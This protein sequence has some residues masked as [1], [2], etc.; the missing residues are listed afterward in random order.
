[1][2]LDKNGKLLPKGISWLPKKELY[3]GRFQYEGLSYAVYAKTLREVKKKLEDQRYQVEHG[4]TGRA[5]R[6]TLN[7]WFDIWLKTYKVGK[8]KDTTIATYKSL[9]DRFVR[10]TLG[11]RYITK[12]KTVEVQRLYN[13]ITEKGLSPKYLKTLH[14]T[15]SNIFKMAVNNDII[16]KNPC[17]QTIRPG[18]DTPERRVLTASEQRW[19]LSFIQQEQYRNIEP[20]ITVLLGTGL[21]IGELLGLKW[22][23]LDLEGKEKTLTVNRTLVR[24]RDKKCFAFQEPKTASGTRTIP[25]QDSVVR[26]LKRQKVNQAHQKLS[27]RWNPPTGFEG[28]VFAGKKGQPQWRSCIAESLDKIIAAMNADEEERA[29]KEHRTPVVI[30]HINLHACRHSFA[31]RCLEAG[32][33]PKIVQSWLGHSSIEITLDLY[34]HVNQDV[35]FENMRRLEALYSGSM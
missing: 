12:I 5:D 8:V 18:I 9:Y 26:A 10:E 20:A 7:E 16:S 4:I 2:A 15:L 34:S 11:G 6:V 35:S 1:M 14:N 23:D 33:A 13:G 32:I 3:M 30:E 17:S 21:R 25:L 22:Q 29:V 19:L 24:I 27:G 28:L 31:T